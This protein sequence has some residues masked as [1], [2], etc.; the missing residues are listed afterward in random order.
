[1]IAIYEYT[2]QFNYYYILSNIHNTFGQLALSLLEGKKE[3]IIH[4]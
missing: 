2:N 3:Q 4:Y 1:M